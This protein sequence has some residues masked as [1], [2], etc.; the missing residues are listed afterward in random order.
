MKTIHI[1]LAATI[2][3][4]T[5]NSWAAAFNEIGD[6]GSLIGSAQTVNA[7][8]TQ[9]IGNTSIN[10]REDLYR[11]SWGGGFFQAAT[12]GSFSSSRNFDT[13]LFLF[14]SVGTF[15][16]ANDDTSGPNGGLGSYISANLLMGDYLLGISGFSNDARNAANQDFR[17]GASGILDHWQGGGN[18]GSYTIGLNGA[19]SENAPGVVPEPA[20][21]ALLGLGFA[22][23]AYSR[24]KQ[25]KSA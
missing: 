8:T 9:I 14:D 3:S 17:N 15:I 19:T 13:M 25:A 24:R 2:A 6:A 1:L 7:G 18:Y 20:S 11:F 22:G 23:M 16:I 4:L 5:T 12:N 21:L 10:D